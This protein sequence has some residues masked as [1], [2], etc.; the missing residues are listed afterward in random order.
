MRLCRCLTFMITRRLRLPS[1]RNSTLSLDFRLS[2]CDYDV[3]VKSSS[4]GLFV[5]CRGWTPTRVGDVVLP[6]RCYTF[7]CDTYD[8]CINLFLDLSHELLRRIPYYV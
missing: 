2:I 3:Y 5:V 8:E 1:S 4:T 6:S 7:R